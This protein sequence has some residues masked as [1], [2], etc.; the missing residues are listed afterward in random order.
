MQNMPDKID[1]LENGILIEYY[2]GQQIV[3]F[4]IPDMKR[5]T[6][7]TWAETVIQLTKER[8]QTLYYLHYFSGSYALT[9]YMSKMANYIQSQNPDAQGFVAVAFKESLIAQSLLPF[10][11][12][13]LARRQPGILNRMFTNK[14]SALTWLKSNLDK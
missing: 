11:N 5:P 9:P 14:Q 2:H 3:V 7:D 6:L 4:E 10:I 12:R 8:E 1:K 13:T